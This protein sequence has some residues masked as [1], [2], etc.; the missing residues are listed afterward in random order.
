MLLQAQNGPRFV[1]LKSHLSAVA[2]VESPNHVVPIKTTGSLAKD[3]KEEMSQ[4]SS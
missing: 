4:I 1:Y 3:C 2:L